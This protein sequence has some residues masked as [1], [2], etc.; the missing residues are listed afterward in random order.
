MKIENKIKLYFMELIIESFIMSVFVTVCKELCGAFRV[1]SGFVDDLF[2]NWRT[3]LLS[4][5]VSGPDN[6]RHNPRNVSSP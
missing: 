3:T 2:I 4:D 6:I 5:N 1:E